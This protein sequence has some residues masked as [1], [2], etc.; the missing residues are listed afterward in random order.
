MILIMSPAPYHRLAKHTVT[1]RLLRC[2]SHFLMAGMFALAVSI[3]IDFDL[4]AS[5]ILN[6]STLALAMAGVLFVLF[7]CQWFVFPMMTAKSR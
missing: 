4:I 7:V 5:I 2:S 3:C 1:K 6:E